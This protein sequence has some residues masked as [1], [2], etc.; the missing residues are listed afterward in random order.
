MGILDRNYEVELDLKTLTVKAPKIEVSMNDKNIFNFK[1]SLKDVNGIMIP[2]KELQ[3]YEVK[4]FAVKPS[5]TTYVEWIG[6][7]DTTDDTI[8]FD[9]PPKFNDEKGT[10]KCEFSISVGEGDEQ[11]YVITEPFTYNV[12]APIHY[13]LNK[14]RVSISSIR[15]MEEDI[16]VIQ[17]DSGLMINKNGLLY[18]DDEYIIELIKKAMQE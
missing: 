13:G 18:L 5:N 9:L 3:N 4:M 16:E 1:L 11:E 7:V 15:I 14:E 17:K 10:Y 8:K 6:S 12:K 2:S